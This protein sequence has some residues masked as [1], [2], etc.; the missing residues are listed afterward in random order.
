[1]RT[2]VHQAKHTFSVQISFH[3]GVGRGG[4]KRGRR[5]YGNVSRT[6]K[7]FPD[8]GGA[9]GDQKSLDDVTVKKKRTAQDLG[10][11]RRN[12]KVREKEKEPRIQCLM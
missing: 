3:R 11:S 1:L 12:S 9:C 5:G 7:V 10:G 4:R 8:I 6:L 2:S